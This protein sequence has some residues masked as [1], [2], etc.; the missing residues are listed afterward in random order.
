MIRDNIV[1][2]GR[3]AVEDRLYVEEFQHKTMKHWDLGTI[4]MVPSNEQSD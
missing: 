2:R 4:E 3:P 1:S